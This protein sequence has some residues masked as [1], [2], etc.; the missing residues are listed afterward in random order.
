MVG[1]LLLPCTCQAVV[2]GVAGRRHMEYCIRPP[3]VIFPGEQSR[4]AAV[5]GVYVCLRRI[6][7]SG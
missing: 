4:V 2:G 5:N 6:P 7:L 1:L 3:F